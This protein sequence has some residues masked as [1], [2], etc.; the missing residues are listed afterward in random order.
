[1]HY[2]TLRRRLCFIS[3]AAYY[4]HIMC[5]LM[6]KKNLKEKQKQLINTKKKQLVMNEWLSFLVPNQHYF[7][8]ISFHSTF[9]FFFLILIYFFLIMQH[10][11]S[12]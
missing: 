11:T 8:S 3:N 12:V 5:S 2:I 7:K 9:F 4:L 6:G 1:M 10:R